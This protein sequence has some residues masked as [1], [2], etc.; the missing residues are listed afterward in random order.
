MVFFHPGAFYGLTAHSKAY[1]PQYLMDQDIVLV[2]T[3]YRLGV[4]GRSRS[5]SLVHTFNIEYETQ[6]LR[7]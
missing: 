7:K 6:Y 5:Y 2:T 3:N 4:L 1:G